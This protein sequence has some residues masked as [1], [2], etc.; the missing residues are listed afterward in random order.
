[1]DRGIDRLASVVV[2]GCLLVAGVSCGGDESAGGPATSTTTAKPS[3]E[4]VKIGKAALPAGVMPFQITA[5]D[6]ACAGQSFIDQLGL[7]AARELAAKPIDKFW[8]L[9]VPT[10][11]A[12]ME[13]FDD[14]LPGESVG[15]AIADRWGRKFGVPKVTGELRDC[16][17]A[18]AEGRAGEIANGLQSGID[19]ENDQVIIDLYDGCD[20]GDVIHALLIS[21]MTTH[22]VSKA[23]ADC[24]AD[25]VQ[26]DYT[27]EVLMSDESLGAER[28]ARIKAARTACE[29][30][31]SASSTSGGVG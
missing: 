2:A 7:E 15:P 6:Q 11:E 18:N 4:A 14:C 29:K 30:A 5:A 28:T 16:V 22:D 9:G 1:M 20:V 31:T 26:G 21:A 25:N 27:I 10:Q 3:A 12:V 17:S 23:I 8:T 13:A 24:V 19:E